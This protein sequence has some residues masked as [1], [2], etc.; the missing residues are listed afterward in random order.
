MPRYSI[1]DPFPPSIG[2]LTMPLFASLGT[3]N[4]PWGT[5]V[6]VAPGV[7]LT[8][9][10]VV[11]EFF[12]K[13]DGVE[14]RSGMTSGFGLGVYQLLPSAEVMPWRVE[15]IFFSEA[16]DIALLA[17]TP[18]SN[19]EGVTS[20]WWPE[21]PV[22]KLF[23]PSIGS[24][25]TAYGYPGS[26]VLPHT[27][28]AMRVWRVV[29]G[30]EF[31]DE[32]LQ[33]VPTTSSG[34][35]LE[36][37]HGGRDSAIMPW[38]AFRTNA[39]YDGGMSGAPVYNEQ[40]ELSG[41]V[42]GSMPIDGTNEHESYVS[43]IWPVLGITIDGGSAV[44]PSGRYPLL[45]LV[46]SGVLRAR[47][48]E[49]VV[50][51]EHEGGFQLSM[52]YPSEHGRKSR[53][54]IRRLP[55]LADAGGRPLI[56]IDKGAGPTFRGFSSVDFQCVVCGVV[57]ADGLREFQVVD[58]VIRCQACDAYLEFPALPERAILSP[59]GRP[60]LRVPIGA[61]RISATLEL[62]PE[63]TMVGARDG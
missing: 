21:F 11:D 27:L 55:Q 56:A 5:A 33:V 17:L 8:A 47:E 22:L 7:A 63:A 6:L 53:R 26:R 37:Y 58:L 35:V 45:D 18:A 20:V 16:L 61:Y 9:R 57:V 48:S 10:H 32:V 38:P 2:Y 49:H 39:R 60:V 46:R 41:I 4:Y 42:C 59:F 43:A 24:L 36:F 3:V 40:N 34:D 51:I 29:G 1:T 23:P 28:G 52:D 25:I 12:R 13:L 15:S 50:A 14:P 62:R 31:D 54:S 19:K 44:L 30:T